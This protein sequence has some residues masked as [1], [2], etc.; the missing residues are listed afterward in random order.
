MA[1]WIKIHR[2]IFDHWVSQDPVKLKWWLVVL[3]EV[4]YCDNK[5]LIGNSVHEIKMG[6]SAYSLR[7]WSIKLGCGV[8]SVVSFFDLLENDGMITRK[9][10]GKGKQ[11]TTLINITNYSR[12]QVLEETQ[13]GT[14]RGTLRKHEGHTTKEGK[15]EKN[16][17]IP[18]FNE[19]MQYAISLPIYKPSHNYG[20]NAVIQ[21]IGLPLLSS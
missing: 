4:N 10:I 21:L 15:K 18:D 3:S 2:G 11:S 7:T 17:D 8:K 1:G 13:G 19:F 5:I 14:L 16:T 20:L 12:Y 6:S 9:T